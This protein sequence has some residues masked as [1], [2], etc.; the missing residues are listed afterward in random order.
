MILAG[1]DTKSISDLRGNKLKTITAEGFSSPFENMPKLKVLILMQ[2][3][4]PYQTKYVMH[5]AFKNLPAL[6]DLWLND[7]LLT[8]FPHP[9]LSQSSSPL[10]SLKYLHLENNA[11]TS[12]T[13]FASSD[14][15]PLLEDL[16]ANQERIHKPFERITALQRLFVHS[17]QIP[18]VQEEDLWL[19]NNLQQLY[20]SGNRLTNATVHPETFRNLSSLTRLD[21]DS[22]NCHYVPVAVQGKSHLPVVNTLY[23]SSNSIT[24]ILQGTFKALD[25]LRSLYLQNNDIVAVEN[26]AFPEGIGTINLGNNKFNFKHENQFTNLS[27]LTSLSLYNNLINVIPDTAFHGLTALSA[28]SLQDNQICRILKIMFKDL[29]SLTSLNLRSNDIAFIEDGTLSVMTK[30]T[31]LDL[32]YNQL[33]TLPAG[34]D[35]HNKRLDKL[36]ISNN[37]ITT[38]A[39]G[40]FVNVTCSGSCGQTSRNI[41]W[42][43]KISFYQK[44]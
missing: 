16:H 38:I 1:D 30:F 19:L 3:Q 32:T 37:R 41:V 21:L 11:L 42:Y 18:S 36:Y 14:F 10:S 7:N 23:L 4:N 33:T 31:Y 15:S 39:N 6:E 40:T 34:G 5:N 29:S 25:T 35:F 27:Q 13:S 2:Q 24:Y 28:L 20:L 43:V 22:N 12:L 9:A 26:G 8:N 44:K 17:N